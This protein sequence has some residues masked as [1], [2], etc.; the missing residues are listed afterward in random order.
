MYKIANINIPNINISKNTLHIILYVITLAL[1]VGYLMDNQVLAFVSLFV[2]AG[3]IY[4]VN[5]NIIYALSISI[6]ITNL[7]LTMQ[8][9]E[10]PKIDMLAMK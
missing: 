4:Y 7:L 2:I 1:A 10:P 8:Y 9:L 6:I 5:K 3:L